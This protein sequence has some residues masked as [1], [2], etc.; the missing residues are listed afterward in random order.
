M[1]RTMLGVKDHELKSG[2]IEG[3]NHGKI[4][5]RCDLWLQFKEINSDQ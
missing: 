5:T 2:S 1:P 3:G 4:P